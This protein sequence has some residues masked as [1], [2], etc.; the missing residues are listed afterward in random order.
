MIFVF[1]FTGFDLH[2][3]LL[4]RLGNQIKLPGTTIVGSDIEILLGRMVEDPYRRQ[5][6]VIVHDGL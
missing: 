5:W 6:N 1:R 3:Q 4:I 2:F